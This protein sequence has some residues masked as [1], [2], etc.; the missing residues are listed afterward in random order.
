MLISP[1]FMRHLQLLAN[2]SAVSKGGVSSREEY[3]YIYTHTH[4]IVNM[5]DKF[6]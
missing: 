6:L 5:L 1:S 2:N 4:I 3:I